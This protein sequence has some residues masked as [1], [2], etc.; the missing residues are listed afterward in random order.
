MTKLE[1]NHLTA[2]ER[3]QLDSLAQAEGI[4]RSKWIANVCKERLAHIAKEAPKLEL[5]AQVKE[6]RKRVESGGETAKERKKM[7]SLL[8]RLES[9]AFQ[10]DK[11][12]GFTPYS[13]ELNRVRT[14]F[15]RSLIKTKN[16]LDKERR[17][18][19]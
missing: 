9:M 5:I 8:G 14:A 19:K 7:L 4:S 1:T 12:R 11:K 13:S 15:V 2:K 18:T 6:L 3:N 16:K 10:E 17:I